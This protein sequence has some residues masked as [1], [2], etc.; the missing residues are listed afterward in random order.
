MKDD[1]F[2][3][4]PTRKI[5]EMLHAVTSTETVL[6]VFENKKTVQPIL[7]SCTALYIN[8]SLYVALVSQTPY[9]LAWR[10]VLIKCIWDV[11]SA[12][13]A[14]RRRLGLAKYRERLSH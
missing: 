7:L 10:L 13:L 3:K 4:T 5:V 6:T 2:H 14:L 11:P 12:N 1:I 9:I 8:F